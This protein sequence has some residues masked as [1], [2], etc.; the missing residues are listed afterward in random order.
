MDPRLPEYLSAIANPKRLSIINALSDKEM[1]FSQLMEVAE[2][3]DSSSLVF[4]LKKLG[5]LIGNKDGKYWLTAEGKKIH[6]LLKSFQESPQQD[7]N[8]IST[9]T[10]PPHQS[11][12]GHI[13]RVSQEKQKSV[14]PAAR[15]G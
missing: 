3:E 10:E 4:H 14:W 9:T 7:N 13:S 15:L 2:I 1:S 11:N 5:E 6:V 12:D 8:S